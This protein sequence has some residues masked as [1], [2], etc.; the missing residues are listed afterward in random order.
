MRIL[1]YTILDGGTRRTAALYSVIQSQSPDVVGLVEAEDP[2]VV[3]D[4]AGRLEMDFVLGMGNYKASAILSRHPIRESINHA[5][6]HGELTKSLLEAT[7]VDA[8]GDEWKLGVLH[9]HAQALEVDEVVRE[10]EIE[11][12]LKVFEPDRTAGRGHLLMGDFNSN[13]PGQVIDPAKCKPSTREAWKKNGGAI[14]RRVVQRMLD[15]AYVDTFAAIKPERAFTSG[16]FSTE[17]PGQRVDY[18]FAHSIDPRRIKRAAIVFDGDAG[19]ASDH[20]P[21]GVEITES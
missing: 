9:L 15:A 12:V 8:G 20:F 3:E 6:L 7:V 4:L 19:E 16:S 2:A 13:A 10:R 21:V 14:P 18:I 1:S 5:P 11:I 17:F